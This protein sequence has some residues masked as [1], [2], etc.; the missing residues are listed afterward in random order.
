MNPIGWLKRIFSSAVKLTLE[1][2]KR[3][4]GAAAR[5]ALAA[6]SV[7]VADIEK[8]HAALPGPEKFARAVQAIRARGIEA[9]DR[10]LHWAIETA[11]LKLRGDLK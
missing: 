4:V 2:T 9:A 3:E 6:A 5:D 8:A 10:I 7:I 1:F 11:V